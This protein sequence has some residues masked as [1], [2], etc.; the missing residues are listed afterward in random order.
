MC[1]GDSTTFGR[2]SR[3]PR[4]RSDLLDLKTTL[5]FPRS[6]FAPQKT[7]LTGSLCGSGQLKISPDEGVPTQLLFAVFSSFRDVRLVAGF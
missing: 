2:L 1:F 7:K 6:S 4:R 5:E 3:P